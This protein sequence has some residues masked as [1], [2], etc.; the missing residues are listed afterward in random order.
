MNEEQQASEVGAAA[1]P[2]A[3]AEGSSGPSDANALP[4]AAETAATTDA[5][6]QAD[7]AALN[8]RLL[9][10]QADF[11][12]FRKR[13]QRERLELRRQVMEELLADLLPVMDH[14]EMGL[15]A[16]ERGG[17]SNGIRAGLEA[18]RAQFREV[19]KRWGVE[20]IEALGRPFDPHWHEAV[21]HEPTADVPPE[22]VLRVT[23]KGYRIGDRLLRAAQVVVAGPAQPAAS[24]SDDA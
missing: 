23:R 8:D 18:V 4:A 20:E 15:Q 11:D 3:G 13:S 2:A 12:N 21:A 14:F 6:L 9:R 22:T 5:E 10:L 19:L 16:A 17:L 1:G 7:I 24:E